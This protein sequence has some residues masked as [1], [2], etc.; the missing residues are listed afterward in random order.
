MYNQRQRLRPWLICV[1]VIATVFCWHGQFTKGPKR[2]QSNEQ[3]THGR[4]CPLTFKNIT[5]DA[6][7]NIAKDVQRGTLRACMSDV[8]TNHHP[9]QLSGGHRPALINW[10]R[11]CRPG[12]DASLFAFTSSPDETPPYSNNDTYSVIVEMEPPDVTGARPLAQPGL[13]SR[14]DLV[15]SLADAGQY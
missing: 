8:N 2:L 4:V 3:L 9:R 11:G 6:Y 1:F 10:D 13:A 12:L 15:L 14:F 5:C 7:I